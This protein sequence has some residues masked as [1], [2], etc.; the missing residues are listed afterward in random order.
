[1]GFM[2]LPEDIGT[3]RQTPASSAASLK[4]WRSDFVLSLRPKGLISVVKDEIK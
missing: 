1:M 4:L 2:K 3:C